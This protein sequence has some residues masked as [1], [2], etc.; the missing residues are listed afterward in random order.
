VAR[1]DGKLWRLDGRK[2]L[3]LDAPGADLLLV[4][5]RLEEGRRAH[6]TGILLVRPGDKGVTLDAYPTL[7]ERRAADLTLA[8][9]TLD[10][11]ALLGGSRDG[12]PA[13]RSA[14]DRAVAALCADAYGAMKAA[15]DATLAYTKTRKQFGVPI[16]SF[17]VL[18]HRM[19][20]MAV[21][22]EEARG[23][24]LL[25]ALKAEAPAAERARFLSSAKAKI[26]REARRVAEEAVQLHGGI[27]MTEE[28]DIGRYLKRI[29][30]FETL[31]GATSA[32]LAEFGGFMKSA[33][34][35]GA[36]LVT[37]DKGGAA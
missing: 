31:F 26:G 29:I 10:D 14:I 4:P 37:A 24:A 15:L 3:V 20:R 36:G 35:A 11:A 6:G 34:I 8:G 5:A 12:L 28:L 23:L 27:G 25:A 22:T 30:A 32:H 7:D 2:S 13:L 16:A 18:Q 9:V 17:Q 21:K 33:E 1:R 19:A